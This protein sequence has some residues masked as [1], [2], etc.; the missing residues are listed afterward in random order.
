MM[1]RVAVT[2]DGRRLVSSGGLG[3]TLRLWDS[4]TGQPIAV[5]LLEDSRSLRSVAV[6]PDGRRFVSGGSDGTLRLWDA[7]TGQPIGPPIGSV[8]V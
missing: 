6:T 8:S 7:Q 3:G 1:R 2:P 4:Q 5:P